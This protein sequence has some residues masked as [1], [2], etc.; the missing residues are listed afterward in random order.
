MEAY[1]MVLLL[2]KMISDFSKKIKDKFADNPAFY[3]SFIEYVKE[4][5]FDYEYSLEYFLEH[6]FSRKDIIKSCVRY[7]QNSKKV[8]SVTAIEKYLIAMTKLYEECIV[9]QRFNNRN[10]FALLPFSSLKLEVKEQLVDISLKEK[11][12]FDPISVNDAD[13][14]LNYLKKNNNKKD[15]IFRRNSLLI[16]LMLLYGFKLEKLKYMI[17]EDVELDKHILNIQNSIYENI[18]IKLELPCEIVDEMG[19]YIDLLKME[20]DFNSNQYL[21]LSKNGKIIDSTFAR[22]VFDS[23]KKESQDELC[24]ITLTGIAKFAIINMIKEGINKANIKLITGMHDVIVDDCEKRFLDQQ[25][26]KANDTIILNREINKKI[27]G[28]EMY[29][30]M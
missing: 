12:S 28:I 19:K 27:R 25:F 17:V 8:N 11:E 15:F 5:Y 23:I 14:L 13:K 16:K 1:N 9:V 24:R 22:T 20:K 26:K 2:E 4:Q 7:I 3:Q 6:D 29:D 10:L 30:K 18:S 21:F